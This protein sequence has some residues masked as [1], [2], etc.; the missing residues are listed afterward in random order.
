MATYHDTEWGVPSHDDRHHFEF[1]VLES[2]QAGLSWRTILNKREG[3]RRLFATFDPTVV[4]TF[5]PPDVE[6]LLSDAGIVRNRL[7]IESAITN[8]RAFLQIQERE[9]GFAKYLWSFNDGEVVTNHWTSIDELPA[10]SPLGDRI[11]KELKRRG[12]RFLGPTTLY[13]HLQAVG[14]VNDHLVSCPR[15]QALG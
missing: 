2:A 6:R 4:A 5:G 3:Y 7:K 11:A 15:W 9:G 8:A 1:L 10:T 14:I 12:F 13:A